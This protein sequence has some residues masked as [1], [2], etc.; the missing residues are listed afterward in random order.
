MTWGSNA[1]YATISC[2]YCDCDMIDDSDE[3]ESSHERVCRRRPMWRKA[4][5]VLRDLWSGNGPPA[6]GDDSDR[7]F[8]PTG[9]YWVDEAGRRVD[10]A[11]PQAARY[12]SALPANAPPPFRDVTT[13][14]CPLCGRRDEARP[15]IR[16][17]ISCSRDDCRD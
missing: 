13:P 3:G 5:D 8:Q 6:S 10:G 1:T 4:L 15:F 14:V 7:R 12:V 2:R 9:G 16:H 11:S 17:A